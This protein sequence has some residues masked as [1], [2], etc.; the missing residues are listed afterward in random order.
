MRGDMLE[1]L[2]RLT[3]ARDCDEE[4]FTLDRGKS[5]CSDGDDRRGSRPAAKQRDLAEALATAASRHQ[6]AVLMTS[7][8]PSAI[9]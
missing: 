9:A 3:V 5:R 1:P 8:V 4:R 2:V 6:T 7:T